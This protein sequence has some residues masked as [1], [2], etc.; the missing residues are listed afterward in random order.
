ME[1]PTRRGVLLDLVLINKKG[2]VG[3]VKVA[4]S[5][6]C[7]GQEMVEFR[8]LCGRSKA[9]SR[10]VALGFRRHSFDLYKDLFG[11]ISSARALKVKGAGQHLN[12]VSFKFN[13]SA[14]LRV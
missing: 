9:T 3:D 11:I 13:I 12:I 8:N 5:L 1:E 14:S 2:L 10:I 6:G 7:S 4:G